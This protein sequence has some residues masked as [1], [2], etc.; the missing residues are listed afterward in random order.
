ML[1]GWSCGPLDSLLR[2]AKRLAQ[3]CRLRAASILSLLRDSQDH[4]RLRLGID[5]A[6][7]SICNPSGM[8]FGARCSLF[9]FGSHGVV[10]DFQRGFALDEAPHM[11]SIV[12]GSS[13]TL[14][15]TTRR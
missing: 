12:A 3:S 2:I 4:R 15:P 7:A 8:S 5:F 10:H 6:R 1:C 9:R 14:R 13:T 11:S